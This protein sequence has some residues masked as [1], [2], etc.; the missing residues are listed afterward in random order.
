MG[1]ETQLAATL[2]LL[3]AHGPRVLHLSGP[4][5]IGKSALL[6]RFTERARSEGTTVIRV[7]CRLTEPTPQG[8]LL[9]IAGAIGSETNTTEAIANRLRAVAGGVVIVLDGYELYG[10]MDAFLRQEFCPAIFEFTRVI[11]SG[12]SPP[13][14]P[15]LSTSE[16]HGAFQTIKLGP[17]TEVESFALLRELGVRPEAARRIN[18]IARG[19][20]LAL[21]VAAQAETNSVSMR[22]EDAAA[23]AVMELV[24]QK[25]MARCADPLTREALEAAS[26]VR[27]MTESMARAILPNRAPADVVDRL[28]SLPFVEVAADG[29]FVHDAVRDAISTS[30]LVTAP[31]RH[32]QYRMAA[33]QQLRA[34]LI[35]VMPGMLWRHTADSLY[36]LQNYLI[37]EGFFPSGYQA[38]AVEPARATDYASIFQF[39][40]DNEGT[41]AAAALR[42][43][44]AHHPDAFRVC[45]DRDLE[46]VG[47]SVIMKG[48]QLGEDA[49][50][51]DPVA[52]AWAEDMRGGNRA[53][54]SLLI[55]RMLDHQE[56][57]ANSGSR[58]ALGVDVKRTYMELRPTL[59]FVY[60]C[61]I[62]AANFDWC[63]PLGFE[64]LPALSRD[65]DG[66]LYHTFRL[67]MGPSSVDGWLNRVIAHELGLV[68][69]TPHWSFNADSLEIFIDGVPLALTPLEFG[70]M[71]TLHSRLGRAVSRADLVEEVWGYSTTATSN[72]VDATVLTLRRKLGPFSDAVETVRGVGYRLR[73]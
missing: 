24:A 2:S 40:D 4:A 71:Q 64:H 31:D 61:G 50:A 8:L 46:T 39:V 21:I 9:A 33:W 60:L 45:R 25:Y 13:S 73:R 43:W 27:R 26:V 37:R 28:R 65:I 38:H 29:L 51:A 53:S 32:R 7:D 48:T 5:G 1:R 67:D 63:Y 10:L 47:V 34:D 3:E 58:G 14:A 19:H 6:A 49:I 70:V 12:Q 69:E 18:S 44:W 41:D 59:R 57:E 20:P 15:W 54:R 56:G 17:L 68:D 66:K 30:L 52:A 11:L 16:W 72:V 36:L 22:G 23:G 55:R 35:H 62:D 42:A